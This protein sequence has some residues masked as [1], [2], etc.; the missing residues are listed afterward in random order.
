MKFSHDHFQPKSC[1]NTKYGD[2]PEQKGSICRENWNLE[3]DSRE[4]KAA[5]YNNR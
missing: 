2:N 3:K 4:A 5:K 1:S